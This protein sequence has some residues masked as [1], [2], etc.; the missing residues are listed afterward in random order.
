REEGKTVVLTTHQ[1]AMAEELSDR[2]AVIRSGELVADLPTGELVDRYAENRVE[3]Q[4]A[5]PADRVPTEK[6]A[7]AQIEEADGGKT[8][9]MLPAGGGGQAMKSALVKLLDE[10]LPIIA[11]NRVRPSLEQVFVQILQGK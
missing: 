6:L 3:I 1:L 2:V 5:A 11:V 8:S 7:D 10:D 4:V 9:I